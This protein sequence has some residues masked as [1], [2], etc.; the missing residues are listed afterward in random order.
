VNHNG[1]EDQPEVSPTTT[2]YISW[3]SL[4]NFRH[5]TC[6]QKVPKRESWRGGRPSEVALVVEG[7]QCTH[8][9]LTRLGLLRKTSDHYVDEN[10]LKTP[11][12]WILISLDFSMWIT[13][14]HVISP[15]LVYT[16]DQGYQR[17]ILW[18]RSKVLTTSG[19]KPYL[20]LGVVPHGTRYLIGDAGSTKVLRIINEPTIAYVNFGQGPTTLLM[21][22]LCTNSKKLWFL[23]KLIKALYF[24]WHWIMEL[25]FVKFPVLSTPRNST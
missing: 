17:Q 6:C 23:E 18:L 2:Y 11:M 3:L 22:I 7:K 15:C 9:R 5:S 25:A 13:L 10:P 8:H 21:L 14:P 24:S 4:L 16:E 19:S 1:Y 20:N 12:T